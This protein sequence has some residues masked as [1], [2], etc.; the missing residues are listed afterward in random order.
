[1]TNELEQIFGVGATVSTD[2][3]S[4][5]NNTMSEA[6]AEFQQWLRELAKK[7]AAS[8]V[9]E[10]YRKWAEGDRYN[11]DGSSKYP[12]FECGCPQHYCEGC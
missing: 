4:T 12:Q 6:E 9:K 8:D 2:K 11:S 1:M 7:S 3:L 10:D 5:T